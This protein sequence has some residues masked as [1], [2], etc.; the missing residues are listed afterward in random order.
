DVADLT[1]YLGEH[2]SPGDEATLTLMRGKAKLELSLE[3]G[4]R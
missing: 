2:K 4:E 1:S 3:I